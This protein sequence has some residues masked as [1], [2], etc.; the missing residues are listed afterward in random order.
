MLC[1]NAKSNGNAPGA[2]VNKVEIKPK[3]QMND[4]PQSGRVEEEMFR[5]KGESAQAVYERHSEAVEIMK[6]AYKI[7]WK[8]L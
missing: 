7:L 5:A 2:K 1:K 3:N 4:T 8:I 6:D